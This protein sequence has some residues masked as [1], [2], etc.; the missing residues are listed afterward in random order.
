M[1][2]TDDQFAERAD[3]DNYSEDDLIE[4]KTAL[5]LPYYTTSGDYERVDGEIE[6]DGVLYNYVKRKVSNDTLYV[7]CL[8]NE[9]KTKLYGSFLKFTE[10]A[11]DIPDNKK[12]NKPTLKKR[13]PLS[14]YH[15]SVNYYHIIAIDFSRSM[16]T[17]SFASN[18]QSISLACTYPPPKAES[19][20][21]L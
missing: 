16:E 21:F 11:I 2:L 8:P 13:S 14:D 20:N 5:N 19:L 6:L 4:L 7:M 17:Y 1:N 9:T 3:R 18:L 12:T 10:Q 15:Y